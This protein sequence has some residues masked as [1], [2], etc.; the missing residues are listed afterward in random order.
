MRKIA[1]LVKTWSN[2]YFMDMMAGINE[3]IEDKK[4]MVDVFNAYDIGSSAL[5]SKNELSVHMLPVAN[6]YEG[7][8]IFINSDGNDYELDNI[9]DSFV[10]LKKPVISIDRK[11][12]ALPYIGI[13]NYLS[14]YAMMEHL[15]KEHG[16]KT[17][18]YVGGTEG[19]YDN[20]EKFRAYKDALKNNNLTYDERYVS[21]HSFMEADGKEAFLKIK[22]ENLPMPD[23]VVCANDNMAVGY[24]RAAEEAG[25]YAPRDYKICGFDNVNEGQ[26]HFPSITSVNKNIK[27]MA[28]ESIAFIM[29]ASHGA[30]IPDKNLISG[31]LKINDS[32]GCNEN[33][34]IVE[35]YRQ[36]IADDKKRD[37]SDS[38]QRDSRSSLCTC[39][40]FEELQEALKTNHEQIGL[41]ES[42]ACIKDEVCRVNSDISPLCYS[43]HMTCY[44]KD[45]ISKVDRNVSPLPREWMN[46]EDKIFVYS[47]FYF[48]EDILGY[49]VIPYKED[50][51]DKRYHEAFVDSISIAIENIR[52]KMLIDS[53]N[54]RFK[55][56]Y[57][58]DQMTGLYNRFGYSAM[59]GKLFSKQEGRVYIVYVDVDNLKLMNDNYGHDIGDMA[60]KGTAECI[61]KVFDD[62]DIHVRMGGDEFLIMG[63]FLD[64]ETIIMKEEKLLQEMKMYSEEHSLPVLLEASIGH[65]FNVEKIET[66]GLEKILKAA[67]SNMYEIKQN[68]KAIKRKEKNNEE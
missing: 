52:Q 11:V 13:D 64:E 21:F 57:V 62:T 12:K 46:R 27:Q 2:N 32:C 39:N 7:L 5:R 63:A 23:A 49:C 30:Q 16:C 35:S 61:K 15:I 53:M 9:I 31:F 1:V 54:Q 25:L 65:S 41:Y 26:K 43:D 6:Q 68:R 3:Y 36:A 44:Y 38:Q 50:L 24:C 17:F 19:F 59:A 33:R 28:K 20:V 47:P 14:E 18:Q 40:T 66:T 51:Y 48:N 55:E 22:S 37:I 42:A 45:G 4:L 29:E 58:I 8:I 60:I 56:L 10:S 67:D 34:D